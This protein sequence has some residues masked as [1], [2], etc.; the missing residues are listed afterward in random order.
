M[1]VQDLPR[2]INATD[3]P[4]GSSSP[5]DIYVISE[6]TT[7]VLGESGTVDGSGVATDARVDGRRQGE[8]DVDGRLRLGP[9]ADVHGGVEPDRRTAAEC[10]PRPDVPSAWLRTWRRGRKRS[11][12]DVVPSRGT[13]R[14]SC[15]NLIKAD[16]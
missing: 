7:V 3:P 4:T 1:K 6:G 11:P 8:V 12:T 14:Q 2:R 15:S 16:P 13:A 5:E 10:T 9:T